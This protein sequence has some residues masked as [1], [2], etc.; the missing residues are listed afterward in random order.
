MNVTDTSLDYF[1][2]FQVHEAD[3]LLSGHTVEDKADNQGKWPFSLSDHWT[4]YLNRKSLAGNGKNKIGISSR[5]C[6]GYS[7]YQP[8]SCFCLWKAKAENELKKVT[9][10][11]HLLLSR[12]WWLVLRVLLK[13]DLK[14]WAISFFREIIRTLLLRFHIFLTRHLIHQSH[15]FQVTFSITLASV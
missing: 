12:E 10:T 2:T 3:Y 9:L 14:D 8:A 4:R 15:L 5:Y 6:G 11:L 13:M 7:Y 1:Q